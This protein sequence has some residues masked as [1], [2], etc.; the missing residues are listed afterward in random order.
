[1]TPH[2]HLDYG[3]EVAGDSLGVTDDDYVTFPPNV[4]NLADLLEAK[5]LTW[6]VDDVFLAFC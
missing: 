3:A 6:K 5:G 2:A 4:T 1:M